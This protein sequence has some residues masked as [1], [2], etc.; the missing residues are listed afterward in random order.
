MASNQCFAYKILKKQIGQQCKI[1]G[2]LHQKGDLGSL[3]GMYKESEDLKDSD[4]IPSD[5]VSAFLRGGIMFTMACFEGYVRDLLD[6]ACDTIL[7]QRKKP[8]L[9][10]CEDCRQLKYDH[11]IM[12]MKETTDLT[13]L[14]ANFDDDTMI[15]SICSTKDQNLD[16]KKIAIKRE[17]E[18]TK[19]FRPRI[20]L[21]DDEIVNTLELSIQRKQ[22]ELEG[23]GVEQDPSALS[24]SESIMKNE[25]LLK[26]YVDT[27]KKLVRDKTKLDIDERNPLLLHCWNDKY[28]KLLN[29]TDQSGQGTAT[30]S[31]QGTAT[32]SDDFVKSIIQSGDII[33]YY[34]V[35]DDKISKV[36]IKDKVAV[37]AMLRLFYGIRC[38]MGHGNATGTLNNPDTL[39]DFPHCKICSQKTYN[40]LHC[41]KIHMVKQDGES[42]AKGVGKNFKECKECRTNSCSIFKNISQLSAVF[43]ECIK[44]MGKKQVLKKSRHFP[45][46]ETLERLTDETQKMKAESII[47]QYNLDIDKEQ[48]IIINEKYAYFHMC[49][50]FHWLE[51]NKRMMYVT[52]RVLIRINQFILVLAYRM[53]IAVARI[54]MDKYKLEDRIWNVPKNEDKLKKKIQKFEENHEERI[55]SLQ[56]F[57]PKR[58]VITMQVTIPT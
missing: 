54:L 51:E 26:E 10:T 5:E 57:D 58:R 40:D 43:D 45:R 30:Q 24:T 17:Y 36:I 42:I 39:K 23:S 1:Y 35:D 47:E 19:H 6:E 56:K 50:I 32:Q 3:P 13:E 14:F 16:L 7:Y 37:C 18:R 46:K 29:P 25:Q 11:V 53:R 2:R 15:K 44:Q 22:R 55:R 33:Y 34:P 12:D 28:S 21:S 52:Y 20:D 41:I 49:R 8:C 9:G 27:K 4:M 48:D 38:I 31:G